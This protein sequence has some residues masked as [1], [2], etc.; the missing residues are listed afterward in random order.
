MTEAYYYDEFPSRVSNLVSLSSCHV[1]ESPVM[2]VWYF[3][4]FVGRMYLKLHV[5]VPENGTVCYG[6]IQRRCIWWLRLR[7][8][9]MYEI[10]YAAKSSRKCKAIWCIPVLP[11]CYGKQGKELHY[12]WLLWN[13]TMMEKAV[14]PHNWQPRLLF[15]FCFIYFSLSG[16]KMVPKS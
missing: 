13:E 8:I 1:L 3:V 15:P 10:I 6:K 9:R 7:Y 16:G 4:S 11:M 12:F 2:S 14:W 5:T